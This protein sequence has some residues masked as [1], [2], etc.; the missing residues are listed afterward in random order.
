MQEA[1]QGI[2][3]LFGIPV[4]I[5]GTWLAALLTLAIYSFLYGDNPIYKACEHLFVGV[6]AAYGVVIVYHEYV[7]PDLYQPLFDPAAVGLVAPKLILI[8]P[9]AFGLLLLS[10]FFPKYSYLSRWPIALSMGA[11]AGFGIPVSMQ[12][13]ILKQLHGCLRSLLP[14]DGPVAEGGVSGLMALDH[15]IVLVGVICV[16]SYF[17]FSMQHKGALGVTS[18]IGIWFLMVAFGA[19]FGNTVM[20]RVSL[21]IGRV[22]FLLYDFLPT[23]HHPF[24][25]P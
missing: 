12:G 10:R 19:G 3:E 23:L 13:N 2:T 9:I 16:L 25:P 24:G 8:I 21:L 15:I 18:R 4:D 14:V 5:W 17:Y 22:Q 7:I 1:Q 20:A 6:S 11:G